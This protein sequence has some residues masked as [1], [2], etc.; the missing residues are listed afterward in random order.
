MNINEAYKT[1]KQ[2]FQS[3]EG[4]IPMAWV[5]PSGIGKTTLAKEL[6]SALDMPM[7]YL[8][9]RSDDVMGTNLPSEDKSKMSFIAHERLLPAIEEPCI[10]YLDEIN[11]AD[12]YTRFALM[13]LIGERTIGGKKLHPGSRIL[14]TMNDESDNYDV[15]ECDQAFKTRCIPVPVFDDLKCVIKYAE[16]EKLPAIA[17]FYS[18][19]SD[20]LNAE[21]AWDVKPDRRFITYLAKVAQEGAINKP[22]LKEIISFCVDSDAIEIFCGKKSVHKQAADFVNSETM[23]KFWTRLE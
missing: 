4:W 15:N 14:L 23:E 8:P 20:L 18:Q 13:E 3:N 19:R 16:R 2:H 10:L 1:A 21:I 6:S 5:G 9:L 22:A 11:R 17:Q 12:R 7:I